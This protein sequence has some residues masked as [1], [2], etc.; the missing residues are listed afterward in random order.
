MCNYMYQTTSS[1]VF[2]PARVCIVC[3][4]VNV[5]CL[6]AHVAHFSECTWRGS[7]KTCVWLKPITADDSCGAAGRQ[8]A[9]YRCPSLLSPPAKQTS[10]SLSLS[11]SGWFSTALVCHREDRRLC[12]RCFIHCKGRRLMHLNLLLAYLGTEIIKDKWHYI[13]I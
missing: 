1:Q 12:I 13:L 8:A 11:G 4:C 7:S 5:A 6:R 3:V 2:R 9:R 10:R